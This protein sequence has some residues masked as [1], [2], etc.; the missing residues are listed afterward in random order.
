MSVNIT[1]IVDIDFNLNYV[2]SNEQQTISLYLYDDM[3]LN[4][5]FF[6]FFVFLTTLR[7]ANI[8]TRNTKRIIRTT[9]TAT[10]KINNLN[11]TIIVILLHG[12]IKKEKQK[13]QTK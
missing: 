9:T 5:Y 11:R 1:Y 7:I 4:C 6:F 13:M 10:T 2:K 12:Q 3:K 8:H